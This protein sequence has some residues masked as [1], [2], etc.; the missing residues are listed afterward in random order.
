MAE[1]TW[2]D[3]VIYGKDMVMAMRAD[4]KLSQWLVRF[5]AYCQKNKIDDYENQVM[6]IFTIGVSETFIDDICKM[7]EKCGDE[8]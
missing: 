2:E 7:F 6:D 4:V 3:K 8:W 1:L 5:F